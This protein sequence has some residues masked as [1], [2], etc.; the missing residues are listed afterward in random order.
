MLKLVPSI[1][2]AYQAFCAFCSLPTFLGVNG[3]FDNDFSDNVA[4]Y[5]GSASS[6]SL[7]WTTDQSGRKV[8]VT[9][10]YWNGNYSTATGY[11]ELTAPTGKYF[12]EDGVQKSTLK[13]SREAVE[14]LGYGDTSSFYGWIVLKRIDLGTN[15]RYGHQMKMLAVGRV[16]SKMNSATIS[17]HSFDGTTL[18]VT[19]VANEV[20][21]YVISWNNAN[22]FA[23][24]N[25]PFIIATGYGKTLAN[26]SEFNDTADGSLPKSTIWT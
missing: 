7:P 25:S 10:Y 2:K 15:K 8:V 22:W 19:K 6:Y 24:A 23:N 5:S 26:D 12:Y 13:L 16:T 1:P 9:N 11:A 4:V 20:G 17:Y 14:L 18:T 21:K 3:T